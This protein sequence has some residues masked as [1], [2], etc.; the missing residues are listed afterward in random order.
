MNI[1]VDTMAYTALMRGESC[2]IERIE[3]AEHV[4]LPIVVV[5]E[6]RA[7]FIVGSKRVKNEA[8][9]VEFLGRERVSILYLDQ[10]S[11]HSYALLFQY[12][13]RAGTPIPLNDLWIAA[14]AHQH[15]YA[16]LSRDAHFQRLPQIAVI[17]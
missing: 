1:V 16:V 14:L 5:G 10:Q 3:Q 9:L 2:A 7:G 8:K 13:K 6:L 15:A 17:T 12:L 4:A 11:A